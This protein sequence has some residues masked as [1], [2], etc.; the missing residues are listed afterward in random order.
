V[1]QLIF[2]QELQIKFVQT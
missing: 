2:N 1:S